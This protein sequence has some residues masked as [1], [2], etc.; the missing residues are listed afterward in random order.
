MA[1]TEYIIRN[2]R[3][4]PQLLDAAAQWFSEKWR[5]SKEAYAE[6]MRQCVSEDCA[7]PQ[8]YVA[9]VGNSIIGGLGVIE[10][11]FHDHPE[12]TPNVCAVYVETAYRRQG[13]AGRLLDRVCR[14]MEA[15]GVDTLYL[16][17]DHIGFYERYGWRFFCMVQGDGEDALSRMY[18]HRNP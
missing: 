1:A 3:E 5:I 6:S 18:I 17:T 15:Y 8:W 13:L 7:V 12:L 10:N 14:D 9:T 11:D 4:C 16:L 2:I